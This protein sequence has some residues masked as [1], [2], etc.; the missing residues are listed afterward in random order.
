MNTAC[1]TIGHPTS[2]SPE[3]RLPL[4]GLDFPAMKLR[5]WVEQRW[6]ICAR[7]QESLGT[8]I[9]NYNTEME[10]ARQ[11]ATLDLSVEMVVPFEYNEFDFNPADA[12]VQ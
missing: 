10:T 3:Y 8:T 6:Q 11:Y 1:D 9:R 4:V 7:L 5:F 2:A 12:Q